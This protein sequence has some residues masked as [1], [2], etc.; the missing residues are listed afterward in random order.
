MGRDIHITS[1]YHVAFRYFFI[2]GE[3]VLLSLFFFFFFFFLLRMVGDF[4]KARSLV[5]M[6]RPVKL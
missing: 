4:V 1:D 6:S 3:E 5:I 2:G